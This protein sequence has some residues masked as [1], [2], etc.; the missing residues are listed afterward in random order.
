MRWDHSLLRKVLFIIGFD[1]KRECD[2]ITKMGSKINCILESVLTLK[3]NGTMGLWIHIN[4]KQSFSTLVLL[5]HWADNSLWWGCPAHGRRISSIPGP[6]PPDADSNSHPSSDNQKCL[7][8]LPTAPGGQNHLPHTLNN[9]DKEKGDAQL[10]DFFFVKPV[11]YSFTQQTFMKCQVPTLS[12]T[13]LGTT[14]SP[15]IC[16]LPF[17]SLAVTSYLRV[18]GDES[19]WIPKSAQS[20]WQTTIPPMTSCTTCPEMKENNISRKHS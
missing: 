9:W 2:S 17:C 11:F 7:Q 10:I 12:G 14:C 4:I 15:S 8:A 20:T 13:A 19:G 6:C 3:C 16:S 1:G 5:T 18:G